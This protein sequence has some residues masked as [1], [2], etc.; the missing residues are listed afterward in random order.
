MFNSEKSY[1]IKQDSKD[2][3]NIYY[4]KG[5]GILYR[6]FEN[7]EYSL[8]KIVAKEGTNNFTSL[9]SNDD[10]LIILYEDISG[11][12]ILS[13]LINDNWISETLMKRKSGNLYS[14]FFDALIIEN[15][16][17][18]LYCIPDESSKKY[19]LIHQTSHFGKKLNP[20]V[21]VDVI[22]SL[23]G[24]PFDIYSNHNELFLIYKNLNEHWSL[25][26]KHY[27]KSNNKWDETTIIDSSKNPFKKLSFVEDS[28]NKNIVYIKSEDEEILIL[29]IIDKI[30][31]NFL[32][33]ICKSNKID[34]CSIFVLDRS[35]WINWI[36]NNK[37]SSVFSTDNGENFNLV[38]DNIELKLPVKKTKFISSNKDLNFHLK[39]NDLFIEEGKSLKIYTVPE[40]YCNIL[41]NTKLSIDDKTFKNTNISI[42]EYNSKILYYEKYFF[43]CEE[44]LKKLNDLISK[45]TNSYDIL[46]KKN[47]EISSKYS[48]LFCDNKNL[49]NILLE[50]KQLLLSKQ[51]RITIL[52]EKLVSIQ[53][54]ILK[55]QSENEKLALLQ[56]KEAKTPFIKRFLRK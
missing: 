33:I 27:S 54:M 50:T 12:I 9:I 25:C 36:A 31:T 2:L 8:S 14:I 13:K 17:H 52:E 39:I 28:I 7:S 4:I 20:P 22:N 18:I 41:Y 15:S 10:M 38:D 32:K 40:L 56:L 3:W 48:D 29:S 30:P 45:Y 44:K 19:L 49:S 6:K 21:L 24:K 46:K 55:I 37:I 47:A 53:E 5:K 34:D 26:Y 11:N 16:L 1:I 23:Y 35:I 42:S 51:I 43:E